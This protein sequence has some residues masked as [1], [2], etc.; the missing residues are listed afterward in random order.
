MRRPILA[1][2]AA[3]IATMPAA[4][5]WRAETGVFRIGVVDLDVT[6]AVAGAGFER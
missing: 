6:A 2:L 4:A 5:D 3:I 1:L